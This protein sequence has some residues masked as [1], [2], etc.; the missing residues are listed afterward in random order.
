MES[1][2][3]RVTRTS[4]CEPAATPRQEWHSPQPPCSHCSAAAKATRSVG[5]ARPGRAGEEPGVGHV[6]GDRGLQPLDDVLL[7]HEPSQT[8]TTAP[9]T[10]RAGARHGRAPGRRSRRPGAGVEH[11]VAP[12]LLLGQASRKP[13]RT[14]QW[15]SCDSPSIRSRPSNRRSPSLGRQV[16][17]DR[18][19][20]SQVARRPPG[21]PLHLV[22]R[23][24]PARP[25]VGEGGVDVPV[26]DHHR[27][28]APAPARPPCDVLGL[29]GGV[30]QRL[31][32]VGEV[33]GGRVEHDLPDPP[34]RRGV[35]RLEGQQHP[36]PRCS[37]RPQQPRLGR[38]PGPLAAL[39]ATNRPLS[40]Y[41]PR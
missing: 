39:E 31:G 26:R 38:L 21:H 29:V 17:Q 32:A 36:R 40:E 28:R 41:T 34:A 7:A 5:A 14:R 10:A 3:V 8:V 13:S 25:L 19:V 35:A 27:P 18:Q 24:R 16:E 37:M 15:K 33:P 30:E 6:A 23:E 12:R 20:R 2:S 1:R 22:G 9:P 11:E 4:G